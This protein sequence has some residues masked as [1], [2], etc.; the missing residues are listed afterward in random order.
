MKGL[1]RKI[2][3]IDIGEEDEALEELKKKHKLEH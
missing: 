1:K 3:H 2:R